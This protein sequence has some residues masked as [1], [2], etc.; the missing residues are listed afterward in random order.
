MDVEKIA[1][2][3]F[4]QARVY[5]EKG[6]KSSNK[7]YDEAQ[8]P[9]YKNMCGAVTKKNDRQENAIL[10][11]QVARRGLGTMH[12]NSL[13][14]GNMLYSGSISAANCDELAHV[15]SYL[16]FEGGLPQ[17]MI[18]I[19]ALGLPGDHA[20]CLVGDNATMI[21]LQGKQVEDLNN[22]RQSAPPTFAIDAWANIVCGYNW[23]PRFFATKMRKWLADGKRVRWDDR[24][25][26]GRGWYDPAGAYLK[27]FLSSPL[28]I[29]L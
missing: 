7:Q 27:A 21:S 11:L 22:L 5:Y 20:F 8:T 14:R 24:D 9:W 13:Q 29:F 15:A 25:R 23:Y 3:V 28:D 17:D 16:A 1:K 10:G 6:L 26:V 2:S 19:A 12:L 18:R 4:K